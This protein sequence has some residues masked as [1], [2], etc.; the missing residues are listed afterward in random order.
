V[1]GNAAAVGALELLGRTQR[2]RVGVPAERGKQPPPD[3]RRVRG[4]VVLA[5]PRRR[6]ASGDC[7]RQASGRSFA[8]SVVVAD[9]LTDSSATSPD[10][11]AESAD[12]PPDQ[13]LA[14]SRDAFTVS[15]DGPTLG[16]DFADQCRGQPTWRA[17]PRRRGEHPVCFTILSGNVARA[18]ADSHC[19]S[20]SRRRQEGAGRLDWPEV[21][22]AEG[23]NRLHST[24]DN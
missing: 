5:Q 3:R 18:N 7:T 2:W 16:T 11:P 14:Y 24:A 10:S 9:I 21:D 12:D 17:V 13:G 1:R 6:L 8:C 19:A 22:S 4:V 23:A 20:G 15:I